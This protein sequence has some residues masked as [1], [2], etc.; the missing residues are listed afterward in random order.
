MLR[1]P[2]VL[3]IHYE[4]TRLNGRQ[5][6][7]QPPVPEIIALDLRVNQRLFSVVGLLHDLKT[8]CETCETDRSSA[9]LLITWQIYCLQTKTFI[10]LPFKIYHY[11]YCCMKTAVVNIKMVKK[12]H[13]EHFYNHNYVANQN[14]NLMT[15]P[16]L[17]TAGAGSPHLLCYLDINMK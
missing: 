3:S 15:K 5:S 10:I 14:W 7:L 17:C 9:A 8:N 12:F 16:L 6:V 1:S 4:D 11:H 13:F 2:I